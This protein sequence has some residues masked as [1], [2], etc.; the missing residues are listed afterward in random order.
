[1][2]LLKKVVGVPHLNFEW[3]PGVLLLNF[4][5]I[6]DPTFKLWG[7]PEVPG[8]WSHFYTM[9]QNKLTA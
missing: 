8:F 5:G 7:G 9:P 4:R 6:P 2:N 1:M 3:G